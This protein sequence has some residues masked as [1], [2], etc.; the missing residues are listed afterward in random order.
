MLW[1]AKQTRAFDVPLALSVTTFGCNDRSSEVSAAS[2]I[3]RRRPQLRRVPTYT[4]TYAPTYIVPGS[5]D[6]PGTPAAA[7]RAGPSSSVLTCL[8]LLIAAIALTG[9]GVALAGM[10][11]ALTPMVVYCAAILNASGPEIAG[12]LCFIAAGFRLQRPGAGPWAW[13]ALA[14]GGAALTLSRSLGPVLLVVLGAMLLLL[15]G[16]R[17]RRPR[18]A[19][20][21]AGPGRRCSSPSASRP[22]GTW[23]S[24]RTASRA[25]RAT[26]TRSRSRSTTST[27]SRAMPWAT[28]VRS[29]RRCRAG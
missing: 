15:G 20:A 5:G 10:A 8:A 3:S 6:A 22:G 23:R 29:T 17:P 19:R 26:A 13:A 28:S 12:A 14:A 21:A 2:W 9:G 27:T 24:S 1:A 25:G 11:V 7:L 18:H 4:G 16:A